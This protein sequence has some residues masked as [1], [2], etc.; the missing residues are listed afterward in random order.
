MRYG[1]RMISFRISSTTTSNTRSPAGQPAAVTGWA[2]EDI[3][4]LGLF[5]IGVLLEQAPA[6]ALTG[7]PLAQG[8]PEVA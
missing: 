4:L 3:A 1:R 6:R 2:F 5:D 7:R 8:A